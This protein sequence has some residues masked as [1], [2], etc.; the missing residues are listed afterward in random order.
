MTRVPPPPPTGQIWWPGEAVSPS[1]LHLSLQAQP[2]GRRVAEDTRSWAPCLAI[3]LLPPGLHPGGTGRSPTGAGILYRGPLGA[4]P[5][6]TGRGQA[7]GPG[8][9]GS[10]AG[11]PGQEFRE[12]WS[13]MGIAGEAALGATSTSPLGNPNFPPDPAP[14]S[15]SHPSKLTV[16]APSAFS[17][18]LSPGRS[19]C[20]VDL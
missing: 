13:V 12:R 19:G 16:P 5:H 8:A 9:V 15:V 7:S 17:S 2:W 1:A 11:R 20:L 4:T 18:P 14:L 10:C 6:Q 3:L